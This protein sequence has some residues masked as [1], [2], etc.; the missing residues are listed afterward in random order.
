MIPLTG[1][2]KCYLREL[3]EPLMTFDLYSDWFK[4][5]LYV[6]R[7]CS[8][9]RSLAGFSRTFMFRALSLKGKGPSREAGAAQSTPA[10]AAA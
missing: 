4:A 9:N 8:D 2:L 3:P 10:E 7:F 5:T 1:A 6:K